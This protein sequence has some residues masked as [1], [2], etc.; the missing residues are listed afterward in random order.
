MSGP[1]ERD[2][3]DA[4]ATLLSSG[5]ASVFTGAVQR[6]AREQE[7][8]VKALTIGVDEEEA[9]RVLR[10][11][12]AEL[13]SIYTEGDAYEIAW[14]RVLNSANGVDRPDEDARDAVRQ[15]LTA[16]GGSQH[17]ELVDAWA[18]ALQ[19]PAGTPTIRASWRKRLWCWLT[20]R[21]ST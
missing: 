16:F 13:A 11:V 6:A 4:G 21:D 15:M 1:S 19:Q 7:Y 3:R 10:K 8:Y 20:R 12:I 5:I 18:R 2:L 9:R 14:H 17:P